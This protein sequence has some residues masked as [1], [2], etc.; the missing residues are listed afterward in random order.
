MSSPARKP[1]DLMTVD[2][3]LSWDGGGHVG[4]IELIDGV[5]RLMAPA[6][7]THS[8]IQLNVGTA[9]NVHLR[10]RKS[11]C[12]AGTEA[13]VL[14]PLAKRINAR[15]PDVVV[16]C[17]P[18]STSG[19]FEAPVLIVEVLS[20]GNEA[21]TWESIRALAPIPSLGEIL[22]LSST[23][24]EGQVFRRLADGAW[25]AEAERYGP[26]STLRLASIDL[27]LPMADV[28]TGTHLASPP[29]P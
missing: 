12:R 22:V 28:Y 15:A 5:P 1:K 19:V 10:N 16:T 9:I 27:D 6:S 7:A 23:A 17:S 13:P 3:F 26:G 18:I 14:P 11:A 4:K 8:V 21:E 25:Q 2:D 20:P 29:A 24:I